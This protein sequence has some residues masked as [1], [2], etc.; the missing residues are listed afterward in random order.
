MSAPPPSAPTK[1]L[2]RVMDDA[3]REFYRRTGKGELATTRCPRCHRTGFPPRLRCP[4]CRAEQDWVELPL[5]G[6]LEAFTTQETALRYGAPA[7]LALARL[8]DDVVV[9]GIAEAP[10]EQLRLGQGIEIELRPEPALGIG[11]LHFHPSPAT[12]GGRR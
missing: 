1:H 4:G 12:G 10:Y 9:P 2:E 11:L 5:H 7:V 6:V 3:A 8:V